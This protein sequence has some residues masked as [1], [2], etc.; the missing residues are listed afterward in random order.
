MIPF[1]VGVGGAMG[2]S[3]ARL[4]KSLG[5]D[6]SATLPKG[7]EL[8]WT[9]PSHSKF[10]YRRFRCIVLS[11]WCSI[12][13]I[14]S[15]SSGSVG[16][17]EPSTQDLTDVLGELSAVACPACSQTRNEC[18]CQCAGCG[19]PAAE[20]WPPCAHCGTCAPCCQCWQAG[21]TTIPS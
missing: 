6:A 10:W 15:G 20:A 18:A 4:I 5:R 17:R 14:V 1:V 21:S 7:V 3:A 9:V 12:L 19:S 8:S 11:G 2:K 13:R 16:V